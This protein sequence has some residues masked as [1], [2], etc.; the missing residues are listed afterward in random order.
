MNAA[1]FFCSSFTFGEYSKS[2]VPPLLQLLHLAPARFRHRPRAPARLD[3]EGTRRVSRESTRHHALEDRRGAEHVV[4][5]AEGPVLRARRGHARAL[6]VA[7]DVI[8]LG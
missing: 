6:E 2:I 3:R 1:S 7:R 5:H 4:G 8:A